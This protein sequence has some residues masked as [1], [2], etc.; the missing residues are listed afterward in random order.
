MVSV[1]V[2]PAMESKVIEATWVL[3]VVEVVK[4]R[5]LKSWIVALMELD[6]QNSYIIGTIASPSQ[7]NWYMPGATNSGRK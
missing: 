5:P 3:N 6:P 4:A 1:D 2:N 7:I